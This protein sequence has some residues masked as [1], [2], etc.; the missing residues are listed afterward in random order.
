LAEY[1][2]NLNFERDQIREAVLPALERD[3]KGEVSRDFL[4]DFCRACDNQQN[5][6]FR[7][8]TQALE[9]LRANAGA[10]LGRVVLDYAIKAAEQGNPGG[11]VAEKAMTHALA[12]RAARGARQVE[13][14]YYR[15]S[16]QTR[17]SRVRDRI[18]QGIRAADITGLARRLL[19]SKSV[20]A[21]GPAKQQGLDDGVK[22]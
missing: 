21:A 17:A 11:E 5:S 1:A 19:K 22:L 12:D 18:D 3:C 10:G 4:D 7:N 2:D 14:H 8:D 9:A 20:A 15:T 6:L 13:E 16:T